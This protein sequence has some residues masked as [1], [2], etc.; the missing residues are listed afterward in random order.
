[1]AIS[2]DL[3]QS[4]VKGSEYPLDQECENSDPVAEMFGKVF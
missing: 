2:M 4:V 1:M 3:D